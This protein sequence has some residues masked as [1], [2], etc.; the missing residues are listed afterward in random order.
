[1]ANGIVCCGIKCKLRTVARASL[2][3]SVLL[4]LSNGSNAEGRGCCERLG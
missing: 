1:M 4:L 2:N 3:P